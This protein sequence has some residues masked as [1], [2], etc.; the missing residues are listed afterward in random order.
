MP[1]SPLINA[2]QHEI[3]NRTFLFVS[4]GGFIIYFM[5]QSFFSKHAISP[6][7]QR[8]FGEH[9][10]KNAYCRLTRRIDSHKKLTLYP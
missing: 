1:H 6:S 7:R 8:K 4:I 9:A 3:S 10:S 5:Q 2:K